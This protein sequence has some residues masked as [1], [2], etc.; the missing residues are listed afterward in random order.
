MLEIYQKFLRCSASMKCESN[1]WCIIILRKQMNMN[2]DH[3]YRLCIHSLYNMMFP[4]FCLSSVHK[5]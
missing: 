5:K 4:E 1:E 3:L 2:R